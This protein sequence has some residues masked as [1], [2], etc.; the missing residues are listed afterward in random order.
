MKKILL[1]AV[2]LALA[3]LSIPSASFAYGDDGPVVVGPVGPSKTVSV[4]W[5]AGYFSN[6]ELVSVIVT[7][8]SGTA[9]ILNTDVP[10]SFRAVV[11]T[12]TF[13]TTGDGAFSLQIQLPAGDFGTCTCELVGLTSGKTGSV[14]LGYVPGE[15]IAYTGSNPG[16]VA[17]TG[18]GIVALGLAFVIALRSRRRRASAATSR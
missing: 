15:A 10:A 16:L 2:V 11:P 4:D 7:C 18:L 14:D 9:T 6:G 5:P 13:P 3:S 17:W 1:A 12:G 8:T